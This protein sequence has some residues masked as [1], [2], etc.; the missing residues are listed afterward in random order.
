MRTDDH[1]Q[2]A[3][4]LLVSVDDG[5]ARHLA[6]AALPPVALPSTNG[7]LV[8]LDG[9]AT[10]GSAQATLG[11]FCKPNGNSAG[12]WSKMKII[13]IIIRWLGSMRLELA[14]LLFAGIVCACSR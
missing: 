6:G 13:L 2:W 8:R 9:T 10:I 11:W 7:A 4:D 12:A 5:A 3:A 14:I 1:Y